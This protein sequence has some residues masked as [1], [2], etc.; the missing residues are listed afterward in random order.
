[1]R[2]RSLHR[3]ARSGALAI[4]LFS[5][6]LASAHRLAPALL[7]LRERE[8]G[9]V[10]VRFKQTLIQSSPVEIAPELP[11]HC[12]PNASPASERDETSVTLTWSEQCGDAGLIGYEVG[13]RGLAESRTDALVRIELADGRR[14]RA[15]LTGSEPRLRVPERESKGSVFVSYLGLGFDHILSGVDH[16]L[17]VLGLILLVRGTRPLVATV[18]AFTLGHSVTLSAAVL[19]FVQFP[20][21]WAETLIAFSIALL[22]NELA[23]GEGPQPS[24]MRRRPWAMAASFGLLHGFGF[25]GALAEV[26]LPGDEIPL[27]LLAFNVGIELGQLLFVIAVVALRAAFGRWLER[28]PA[29]LAQLPAYAIGTLAAYWCFQRALGS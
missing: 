1:M 16:L 14:V 22:A 21:R 3:V 26:G 8:Q 6:V 12:A 2:L 10:E 29:R 7:E 20:T 5:P 23:R 4:V 11:P 27:A 24:A 13:V 9:V 28:A 25:A 15:V 18:T 17:F 19:G